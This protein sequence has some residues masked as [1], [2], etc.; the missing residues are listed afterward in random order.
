MNAGDALIGQW[1]GGGWEERQPTPRLN[2]ISS[3]S[4]LFL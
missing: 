1:G 3:S 2:C 4:A